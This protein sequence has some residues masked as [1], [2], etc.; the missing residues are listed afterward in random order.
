M[1]SAMSSDWWLTS[2][3]PFALFLFHR[4][5]AVV[6]DESALPFGM[7]RQQHLLNDLRQ[8]VGIG[9]DRTGERIA[10][11]RAKADALHLWHFTLAQ[12]HAVV[13]DHDQRTVAFD[14]R[15][16]RG[17]VQRHDLELL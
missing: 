13:V 9:L 17:V 12:R 3:V 8:R 7:L 4:R 14:D 15:P 10:T 6:I 1:S 2:E 16:L 11:E 5:D